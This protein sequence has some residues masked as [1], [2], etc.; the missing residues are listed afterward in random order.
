MNNNFR[1]F[2]DDL[3]KDWLDFREDTELAYFTEEDKKHYIQFDKIS[4]RILN[5]VPK[6]NSKYLK[7]YVFIS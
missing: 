4:E 3:L 1:E 6:Q 5:S 2:N 7:K